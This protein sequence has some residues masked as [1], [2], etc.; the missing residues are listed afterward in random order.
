VCESHS[1]VTAAE[2]DTDLNDPRLSEQLNKD[3]MTQ[4]RLVVDVL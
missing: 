3:V 2:S 4:C 1:D